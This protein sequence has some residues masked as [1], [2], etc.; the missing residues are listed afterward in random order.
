MEIELGASKKE[1][2][3]SKRNGIGRKARVITSVSISSLLLLHFFLPSCKFR[4][5]KKKLN[6][7]LHRQRQSGRKNISSEM[8]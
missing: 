1:E 6:S 4:K 7:N 2:T 8:I 3:R 5:R